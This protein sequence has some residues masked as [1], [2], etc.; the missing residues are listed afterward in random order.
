MLE[1][2]SRRRLLPAVS[3][4]AGHLTTPT[5]ARL[6]G[7]CGN[8][9]PTTSKSSP[10]LRLLSSH[11]ATSVVRTRVVGAA[12]VGDSLRQLSSLQHRIYNLLGLTTAPATVGEKCSWKLMKKSTC[13][14]DCV[15]RYPLSTVCTRRLNNTPS[16]CC[17]GPGSRKKT[18]I[19]LYFIHTLPASLRQP[20]TNLSNSDVPSSLSGT[21]P[22]RFHRLTA[23]II[24]HPSTLSFRA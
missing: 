5:V 22:H 14:Y 16:S 7:L 6:P 18:N 19:N 11:W 12:N 15:R 10:I 13:I 3:P 9:R 23:L 8:F 4:A 17:Y 20:R 2:A 1:G 24:H 21:S